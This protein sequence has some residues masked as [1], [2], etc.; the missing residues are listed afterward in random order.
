M[1]KRRYFA[2]RLLTIACQIQ[3]QDRCADTPTLVIRLASFAV[4]R[5]A[6]ARNTDFGVVTVALPADAEQ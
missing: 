3:P 6:A 2:W 4:E 1:N 5:R